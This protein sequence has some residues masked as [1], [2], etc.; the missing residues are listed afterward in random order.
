M[1][2]IHVRETVNGRLWLKHIYVIERQRS[3]EI[4]KKLSA[5][6]CKIFIWIAVVELILKREKT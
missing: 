4:W 1:L 2:L 5:F 3:Y 6:K